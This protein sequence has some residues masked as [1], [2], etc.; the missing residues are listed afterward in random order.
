MSHF[1]NNSVTGVFLKSSWFHRIYSKWLIWVFCLLLLRYHTLSCCFWTYKF[2]FVFLYYFYYFFII[3]LSYF[4][5]NIRSSSLCSFN[6]HTPIIHYI[7][8]NSFA[9][10]SKIKLNTCAIWYL[11]AEILFFCE[12][13]MI[14]MYD[15]W[16]I[17]VFCFL[18]FVAWCWQTRF[19]K[20]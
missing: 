4:F 2:Y 15:V 20:N 19:Y 1:L 9:H 16:Y 10:F 14:Y 3:Y 17:K 12:I 7:S 13:S 11:S 18:K 8:V 5:E 6:V